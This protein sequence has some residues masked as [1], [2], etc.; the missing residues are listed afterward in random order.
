MI[1]GRKRIGRRRDVY[2]RQLLEQL[3]NYNDFYTGLQTYTAGVYA[4]QNGVGQLN[5]GTRELTAGL[6]ELA[7]GTR[8]LQ[9]GAGALQNGGSALTGGIRELQNGAMQL[10]SGL[11]EFREQ[12]IDKLVEA[13]DG[14][15]EEL[16]AR[17]RAVTEVSRQ[18]KSFA[19]SSS[20]MDG[21]VKFLYRTDAI[22]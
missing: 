14:D 4:A 13:V 17:I 1:D 22:G 20:G 12:G 15:L 5:G 10:N 21:S 6:R 9:D 11:R 7:D 18:Y 19:G 2:K 16:T 3:D 8:T